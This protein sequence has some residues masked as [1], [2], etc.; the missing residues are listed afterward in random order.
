MLSSYFAIRLSEGLVESYFARKTI[1][2]IVISTHQCDSKY[3]APKSNADNRMRKEP[4]DS[5][6]RRNR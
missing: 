3:I 1:K 5:A 6:G 4:V 2:C